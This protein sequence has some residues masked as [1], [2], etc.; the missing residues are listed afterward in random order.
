MTP[1]PTVWRSHIV[2]V[3]SFADGPLACV[4]LLC[5]RERGREVL[6]GVPSPKSCRLMP[7]GARLLQGKVISNMLNLCLQTPWLLLC[8]GGP[9]PP[10]GEGSAAIGGSQ[11]QPASSCDWGLQV[12]HR[13]VCPTR[14]KQHFMW[15][16]W[17]SVCVLRSRTRVLGQSISVCGVHFQTCPRG[18][19]ARPRA[20]CAPQP[21]SW[22]DLPGPSTSTTTSTGVH[23]AIHEH[24]HEHRGSHGGVP[25]SA[26]P[27]REDEGGTCPG[28]TSRCW[29]PGLT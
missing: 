6:A 1:P 25:P 12:R 13:V 10:P 14:Q 19:S 5:C 22:A 18:A 28:G 23:R 26:S 15:L 7:R 9:P 21:G 27:N 2:L 3:G 24:H 11:P 4:R 29:N 20:R 8:L 16:S 17:G